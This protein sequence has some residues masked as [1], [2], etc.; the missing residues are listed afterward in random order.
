MAPFLIQNRNKIKKPKQKKQKNKYQNL[1]PLRKSHSK[2]NWIRNKHEILDRG[3][4]IGK[5]HEYIFFLSL[6]LT[7][8]QK[9]KTHT[10]TMTRT[11]PKL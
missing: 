7:I 11:F 1:L 5:N 4:S 9:K 3:P 8:S 6:S 2:Q 10:H